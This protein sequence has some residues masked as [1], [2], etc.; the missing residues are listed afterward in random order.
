MITW[1]PL[2]PLIRPQ[3]TARPPGK[4]PSSPGRCLPLTH[5]GLVPAEGAP[6]PALQRELR[7]RVGEEPAHACAVS[8]RGALGLCW[9]P[10]SIWREVP[11]GMG[12][13]RPSSQLLP[14]ATWVPMGAPRSLRVFKDLTPQ[15][16][17]TGERARAGLWSPCQP[18]SSPVT[19]S[20]VLGGN[21]RVKQECAGFSGGF[22]LCLRPFPLLATTPRGSRK[23]AWAQ[24]TWGTGRH[25]PA[26]RRPSAKQPNA[27]G[28]RR[29]TS[30]WPALRLGRRG[31]PAGVG[32]GLPE[33]QPQSGCPVTGWL[34]TPQLPPPTQPQVLTTGPNSAWFRTQDQAFLPEHGL[35]VRE[36]ARAGVAWCVCTCV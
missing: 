33:L 23:W 10:P 4:S 1:S 13:P 3:H 6:P 12:P 5:E 16:G 2:P 32:W 15:P 26:V 31:P 25:H 19:W 18:S 34:P 20:P 36:R 7:V 11:R 35:C 24:G 21:S 17:V 29:P 8:L 30:C 28:S 27:G 22:C 9:G 14:G